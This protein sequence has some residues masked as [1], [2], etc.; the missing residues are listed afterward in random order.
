MQLGYGSKRFDKNPSS[1]KV[2]KEFRAARRFQKLP[3]SVYRDFLHL[4]LGEEPD[5]T[6]ACMPTSDRGFYITHHPVCL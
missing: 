1:R 5:R 2:R 4:V 6:S 3:F